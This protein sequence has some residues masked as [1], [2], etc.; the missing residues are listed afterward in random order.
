MV[1]NLFQ[2]VIQINENTVGDKP[3]TKITFIQRQDT[4]WI[5]GELVLSIVGQGL[6]GFGLSEYGNE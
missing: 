5:Q 4:T 2:I 3:L 1:W 6:G